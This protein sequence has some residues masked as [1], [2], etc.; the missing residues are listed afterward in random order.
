MPT[1]DKQFYDVI[2]GT[3]HHHDYAA[4]RASELIRMYGKVRFLEV[5]CACGILVK[6]LAEQGAAESR[7]I[8]I[9]DYALSECCAVGSVVKADCASLPF[10]DGSF[11]VIHSWAMFGYLDEADT[12]KAIHECKRVGARQYHTIDYQITAP[13]PYWYVF[14]RPREWWDERWQNDC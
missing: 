7:G 12:L 2:W 3:I 13:Y 8:D 11:D 5:G 4:G 10:A 14:M 9:S 6:A 1:F